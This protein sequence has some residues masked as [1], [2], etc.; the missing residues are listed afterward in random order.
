MFRRRARLRIRRLSRLGLL[1]LLVAGCAQTRGDK[2]SPSYYGDEIP[3]CGSGLSYVNP[4]QIPADASLRCAALPDWCKDRTHVFVINGF[5]PCYLGN[6]N[7]L[8][9]HVRHLGFQHVYL[10]PMWHS[11]Q[12][13]D[14]IASAKHRDPEARIVLVGF[15]AGSLDARDACNALYEKGVVVDLLVYIGGDRIF[16]VPKSCPDN[17]VQILNITGHGYLPTGGNLFFNGTELTG[18]TNV[19]LP[20]WHIQLPSRFTTMEMLLN[21][22]HDVAAT[23]PAP[24]VKIVPQMIPH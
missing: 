7:G 1:L 9:R 19:R 4:I 20:D 24:A 17:A 12:V 21:G 11:D 13:A 2:V 14:R 22:L 8:C 16:D 18:A 5:D 3:P 6:L 15:S 10:D 23:A